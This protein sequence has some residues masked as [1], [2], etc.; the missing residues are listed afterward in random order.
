MVIPAKFA[1]HDIFNEQGKVRFTISPDGQV[2]LPSEVYKADGTP[3]VFESESA[4]D[5]VAA[6]I[7][8]TDSVNGVTYA[9]LGYHT[10]GDGGDN[11]YT[12][13]STGRSGVTLNGFYLTGAGAD[14]YY[15]AVNKE[16]IHAAQWGMKTDGSDNLAILNT[17]ITEASANGQ[18]IVFGFGTYTLSGQA[19]IKDGVKLHGRGMFSGTVILCTDQNVDVFDLENAQNVTVC[20]MEITENATPDNLTTGGAFRSGTG[21]GTIGVDSTDTVELH[22]LYLHNFGSQACLFQTGVRNFNIHDCFVTECGRSGFTFNGIQRLRFTNNIIGTTGDDGLAIN[23]VSSRAVV[24]GNLFDGC[25]KHSDNVPG[26]IKVHGSA[27]AITGNVFSNVVT[28]LYTKAH[29]DYEANNN[30][31]SEARK[32]VYNGNVIQNLAADDASHGL[33]VAIRVEQGVMINLTNNFVNAI[34]LDGNP[35][36]AIEIEGCHTLRSSNNTYIG[37]NLTISQPGRPVGDIQFVNDDFHLGMGNGDSDDDYRLI[38]MTSNCMIDRATF[39]HCRFAKTVTTL[40]KTQS[41]CTVNELILDNCEVIR[42]VPHS[43]LDTNLTNGVGVTSL[44]VF[45]SNSEGYDRPLLGNNISS[46]GK[47][48]I[49]RYENDAIVS[50][51]ATLSADYTIGD[52][53]ISINSFTPSRDYDAVDTWIERDLDYTNKESFV[54]FN[55]TATVGK[56]LVRGRYSH[57]MAEYSARRGSSSGTLTDPVFMDDG[58]NVLS[59]SDGN[60]TPSAG[61]VRRVSMK[62]ANGSATDV[63]GFNSIVEGQEVTVI[64]DAN[65]TFKHNDATDTPEATLALDGAADW[66]VGAGGGVI[67]FI[68]DGIVAKEIS[69]ASY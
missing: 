56:M 21:G 44:D 28:A 61:W 11:R 34:G 54:H 6:L 7:A 59:V 68:V 18:W 5:N 20:H 69:R 4:V 16:V 41:G 57:G 10:S 25:G 66:A 32:V 23:N 27:V 47:I 29:S 63:Y 51:S 64:A 50:E 15:E 14:D 26:A 1:T 37:A 3:V 55:S 33:P 36:K 22:H 35:R 42:P 9:T 12:Y 19:A 48:L 13:R 58:N 39:R 2:L 8:K 67:R 52:A 31:A 24:T 49:C 17:A 40:V 65:T 60:T 53:T 46:G 45:T 30:P 38:S 62:T 43:T